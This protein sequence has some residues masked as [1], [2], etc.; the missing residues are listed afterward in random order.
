MDYCAQHTNV[1]SE[2]I[3]NKL[4]RKWIFLIT[5]IPLQSKNTSNIHWNFKYWLNESMLVM[6]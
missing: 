3:A 2:N 5:E 4:F 6:P 1:H